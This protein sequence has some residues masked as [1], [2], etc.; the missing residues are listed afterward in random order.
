M[1]AQI[2]YGPQIAPEFWGSPKRIGEQPGRVGG[3]TPFAFHDFVNPLGRNL[4]M[5]RQCPLCKF[6]G[7]K[8][9][10]LEDD[11][12]MDSTSLDRYHEQCS[13]ICKTLAV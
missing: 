6:Q 5:G 13:A 12:G 2:V 11:S 8:K 4:Q 9:F 3:D 1:Q 7:F 10:F